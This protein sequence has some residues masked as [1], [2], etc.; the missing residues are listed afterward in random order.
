MARLALI[1]H[2]S[3]ETAAEREMFDLEHNRSL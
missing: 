3:I 1:V 2:V